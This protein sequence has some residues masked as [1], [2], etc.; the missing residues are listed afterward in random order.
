MTHL[1]DEEFEAVL[2]K[3]FPK[4]PHHYERKELGGTV[5]AKIAA[6]EH[7]LGY[8]LTDSERAQV[9]GVPQLW[10]KAVTGPDPMNDQAHGAAG[11]GNQPQTH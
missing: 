3:R 9:K 8:P 11:G 1:T 7:W 10:E 2:E 5:S 4:W 6:I